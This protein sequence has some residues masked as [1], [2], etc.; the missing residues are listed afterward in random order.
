[1]ESDSPEKNQ[2]AV[3]S[4]NPPGRIF[5]HPW[6]IFFNE[7]IFYLVTLVFSLC[8]FWKLAESGNREGLQILQ[9]QPISLGNFLGSFTFA[10]VVILF[11][12]FFFRKRKLKAGIFRALFLL[13]TF[14]AGTFL[15]GI[16]LS[17]TIAAIII[18]ALLL[19]WLK[20]PSIIIHNLCVMLAIAGVGIIMGLNLKPLAIIALLAIFSIYDFIAVY[21]TK[22][23]VR[24]AREMAEGGALFGYFVPQELSEMTKTTKYNNMGSRILIIGGGD[25][26]FPLI[27]IISVAVQS[28]TGAAIVAIF[29]LFGLFLSFFLFI[30][31]KKR[32][33]LP[34]LPPIALC[35]IL[36]YLF[37]I[38]MRLYF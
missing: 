20:K 15:A 25:I 18:A 38:L 34:A 21:Q 17:Q 33:P 22:H 13:T 27:L 4:Q 11:I 10:T 24:I 3:G 32:A 28:I 30:S 12:S 23:M 2:Q 5:D 29:T 19:I 37:V 1:M 16:W 31:Q 9:I 35:S 8:S 14:A 6:K 36:G 7:A 26:V